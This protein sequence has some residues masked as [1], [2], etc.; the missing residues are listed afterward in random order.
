MQAEEIR[1]Y[2]CGERISHK[3]A[4]FI[5]VLSLQKNAKKVRGEG[6]PPPAL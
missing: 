3:V 2:E 5:L 4:I 1:V 6:T